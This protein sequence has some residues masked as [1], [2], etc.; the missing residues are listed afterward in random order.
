V[1]EWLGYRTYRIAGDDLCRLMNVCLRYGLTLWGER[2]EGTVFSF[3]LPLYR[4]R[5]AEDIFR[6][7]NLPVTPGRIGGLAGAL[8]PMCR[9]PGL[10]VGLVLAVWIWFSLMGR[11][12]EVRIR[13]PIDVDEDSLLTAL[14]ECG[15]SE[16]IRTASVDVDRVVSRFLLREP[17]IAFAAVHLRGT[18]AEVEVIPHDPAAPPSE[19][20]APA[21]VVASR[22]GVIVDVRAYAGKPTVQPGQSV[23]AG[24][25]LVSGVI[26]TVGGTRLLHARAEVTA[27]VTDTLSVSVPRGVT[28][29]V[30][31]GRRIRGLTLSVFG[32]EFRIGSEGAVRDDRQIYVFGRYLLPLRVGVSFDPVTEEVAEERS[33]VETVRLAM[34]EINRRAADLVGDGDVMERTVTGVWDGDVYTAS[35]SIVF[36]TNI[37]KSL[38]FSVENR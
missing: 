10:L 13:S 31:T 24:D 37:A 18:V 4:T 29:T 16:G 35:L 21:H 9:R 22:P 3:R 5:F 8:L 23:D 1:R 32:K 11:V 7:E 15:L 33:P 2:E 26:T 12:W 27:R 25:L 38:A 20:T 19:P 30:V 36:D 17:E 14:S 6:Q 28:R 34:A